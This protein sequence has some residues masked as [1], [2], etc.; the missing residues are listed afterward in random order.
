[1]AVCQSM[2][3]NIVSEVQ[4]LDAGRQKTAEKKKLKGLGNP[5]SVHKD[6]HAPCSIRDNSL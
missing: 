3:I 4:R 6:R 2:E 5:T 1:M